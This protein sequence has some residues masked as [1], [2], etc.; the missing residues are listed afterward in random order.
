ML[1]SIGR[2]GV[3]GAVDDKGYPACGD[4]DGIHDADLVGWLEHF[5]PRFSLSVRCRGHQP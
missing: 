5:S 1:P 2:D 4:V 3:L